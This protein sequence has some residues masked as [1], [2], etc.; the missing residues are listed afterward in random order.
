MALAA[1]GNLVTATYRL[2]GLEVGKHP[3]IPYVLVAQ[4]L[5]GDATLLP[6]PPSR[7]FV[8]GNRDRDGV[9]NT[10]PGV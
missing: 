7:S 9:R 6:S 3:A 5:K 10:G 8:T 1:V 4:G 2:I